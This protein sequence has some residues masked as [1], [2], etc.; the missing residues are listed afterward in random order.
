M[1]LSHPQQLIFLSLL[2]ILSSWRPVVS[3]PIKDIDLRKYILNIKWKHRKVFQRDDSFSMRKVVL[4][5]TLWQPFC[6]IV[7]KKGSCPCVQDRWKIYSF[8]PEAS[9]LRKRLAK[10]WFKPSSPYSNVTL[11]TEAWPSRSRVKTLWPLPFL[12]WSKGNNQC[13]L[14]TLCHVQ[15]QVE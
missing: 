3:F 4:F 13:I 5:I 2:S 14:V 9:S 6:F 8:A 12:T 10:K 7:R 15:S 11:T 1:T